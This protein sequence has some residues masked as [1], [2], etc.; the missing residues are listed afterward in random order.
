M[1]FWNYEVIYQT[2]DFDTERWEEERHIENRNQ[3]FLFLFNA[4]TRWLKWC[5]LFPGTFEN[6]VNSFLIILSEH[7]LRATMATGG[8]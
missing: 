1:G 8:D 3:A 2:H 4:L 7:M 6:L 5:F